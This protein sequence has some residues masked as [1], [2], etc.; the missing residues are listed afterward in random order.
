MGLFFL[1]IIKNANQ[2]YRWNRL[3][4]GL[5]YKSAMIGHQLERVEDLVENQLDII[6]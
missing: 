6:D 1:S 4:F 5:I 2:M 3:L